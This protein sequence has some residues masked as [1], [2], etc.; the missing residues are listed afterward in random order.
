KRPFHEIFDIKKWLL[1]DWQELKTKFLPKRNSLEIVELI[2]LELEIDYWK[3]DLIKYVMDQHYFNRFITKSLPESNLRLIELLVEI[4]REKLDSLLQDKEIKRHFTRDYQEYIGWMLETGRIDLIDEETILRMIDNL[5]TSSQL[6]RFITKKA[7]TRWMLGSRVHVHHSR[8]KD[9]NGQGHD[10]SDFFALELDKRTAVR[11]KTIEKIRELFTLNDYFDFEFFQKMLESREINPAFFDE[12][13]SLENLDTA[14]KNEENF[15]KKLEAIFSL[16]HCSPFITD[17]LIN[18]EEFSRVFDDILERSKSEPNAFS[19][20]KP[21]RYKL[22]QIFTVMS[23]SKKFKQ[24][25][26]THSRIEKI[27]NHAEFLHE[28]LIQVAKKLEIPLP[29]HFEDEFHLK[30][31][32]VAWKAFQEQLKSNNFGR[33]RMLNFE[34]P[35]QIHDLIPLFY[36]KYQTWEDISSILKEYLF[37]EDMEN[38]FDRFHVIRNLMKYFGKNSINLFEEF[39]CIPKFHDILHDEFN[40]P[41]I[42][43]FL[44]RLQNTSQSFQTDLEKEKFFSQI[45]NF[46]ELKDSLEIWFDGGPDPKEVDLL[47]FF[48]LIQ[49]IYPKRVWEIK[50]FDYIKQYLESLSFNDFKYFVELIKKNDPESLKPFIDFERFLRYFVQ[51]NHLLEWNTLEKFMNE[52]YED[53]P[54]EQKERLKKIRQAMHEFY[55]PSCQ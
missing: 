24:E 55:H 37:A 3:S 8:K 39:D 18:F 45:M 11:S 38:F 43:D 6:S 21:D 33:I 13:Y 9:M 22:L 28:D 26:F 51:K 4:D 25:F 40:F 23:R 15:D 36:P 29:E 32:R 16:H 50:W 14:F 48:Y 27:C 5:S 41:L 47:E 34:E 12:I 42:V 44:Y 19:F 7:P 20:D 30:R 17:E 1:S 53:I 31:A 10:K 35:K 52:F 54:E 46:E 49:D 2:K